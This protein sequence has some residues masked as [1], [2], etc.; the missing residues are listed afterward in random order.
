[1]AQYIPF[2]PN[3]EVNG[4]TILSFVGAS[5]SNRIQNEMLQILEE[6]GIVA[7]KQGQWYSQK[8]WLD[9]F[10][11]IAEKYGQNTLFSIGKAIPENAQ[12][13][14]GLDTLEKA[15]SSIDI[16]YHMNH[17]GGEIGN[18]KLI[19]YTAEKQE[20][21]MECKNPYP[22][23]F[24][25]G[26]ITTIARKFKPQEAAAVFVQLSTNHPTRNSGAESCHYI[27]TW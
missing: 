20:A 4:E 2:A 21:I 13:P 14:P 23:E 18:Y 17:R 24:D 9:A 27:L 11:K 19:S 12:F 26:I 8:S 22:S 1:M 15:L 3:V 5:P 6:S 7:P 16:A 10:K 25:R